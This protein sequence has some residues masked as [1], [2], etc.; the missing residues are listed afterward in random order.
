M[1]KTY[2]LLIFIDVLI[3]QIKVWK[4]NL[5]DTKNF[6]LKCFSYYLRNEQIFVNYGCIKLKR[7]NIY[8]SDHKLRNETTNI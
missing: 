4:V 1:A 5:Y 7:K 2:P 8:G 6:Y 3:K